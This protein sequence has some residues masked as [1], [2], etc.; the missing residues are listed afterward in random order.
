MQLVKPEEKRPSLPQAPTFEAIDPILEEI[1]KHFRIFCD[2]KRLDDARLEVA[3]NDHVDLAYRGVRFKT[4]MQ[5]LIESFGRAG[6]YIDGILQ[7]GKS[8]RKKCE[9]SCEHIA[10]IQAVLAKFQE[11]SQNSRLQR[12]F[13][14]CANAQALLRDLGLA[15]ELR[16]AREKHTKALDRISE[17]SAPEVP[18]PKRLKRPTTLINVEQILQEIDDFHTVAEA[19][20][21][22]RV[23]FE[24]YSENSSFVKGHRLDLVVEDLTRHVQKEWR[25]RNTRLEKAG[26][27]SLGDI[28]ENLSKNYLQ[29]WIMK[30]IDLNND[31]CL[32]LDE[33][34]V[35]FKKVV[36]EID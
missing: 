34:M 31:G 36:D 16:K 1:D 30:S 6:D 24:Y 12:C 9:S 22:I 7:Q 27:K 26:K 13:D 33:A 19:E 29:D 28:R 14:S 2:H 15:E 20:N 21:S 18:P 11:I 25:A 35:G 3:A 8:G 4:S 10:H 32:T 17:E 23:L 5:S